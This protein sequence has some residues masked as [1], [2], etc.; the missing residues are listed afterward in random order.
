MFSQLTLD[1]CRFY[2]KHLA[3][4]SSPFQWNDQTS[5]L[6]ITNNRFQL[7]R[8]KLGSIMGMMYTMFVWVRIIQTTIFST[9]VIDERILQLPFFC[10]Y[11][12]FF[13]FDVLLYRHA[14]DITYTFNQ[15]NKNNC[16]FSAT[17]TPV[18]VKWDLLGI[19]LSYFMAVCFLTGYM[20]GLLFFFNRHNK[21]YPYSLVD[22]TNIC[23]TLIFMSFLVMEVGLVNLYCYKVGV[24]FLIIILYFILSSYWLKC[25]SQYA[26]ITNRTTE[27]L[28][29]TDKLDMTNV[30]IKFQVFRL[31]TNR[32][33]EAFSELLLPVK[34]LWVM[35][36]VITTFLSIRYYAQMATGTLWS[37]VFI[38]LIIW[39]SLLTVFCPAGWVW[40]SSEKTKIHVQRSCSSKLERQRFRTLRIFGVMLGSLYVVKTYTFISMFN[41]ITYYICT[42]LISFK[43]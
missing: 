7:L 17:N 34:D 39:T 32:F 1:V 41:I 3:G 10:A 15:M 9:T 23:E 16:L 20:F 42:L 37:V 8:W 40:L 29:T 13:L 12:I 38:S 31:H 21:N 24:P 11:N 43:I 36:V 33:N 28:T 25:C 6:E 2:V 30:Y 5:E 22:G 35:L 4:I 14:S 18:L 19:I 26:H 27:N